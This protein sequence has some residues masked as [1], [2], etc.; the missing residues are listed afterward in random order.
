MYLQRRQLVGTRICDAAARG[1]V[2]KETCACDR[3][4][5]FV[6]ATKRG[7]EAIEAAAP[8]H[9]AAVRRLF[10]DHLSAEDLD[11]ITKVAERVSAA[12]AAAAQA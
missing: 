10:V 11:V 8:G 5:A 4:R 2:N 3:R 9:V 7:R 12:V 6:V 1:L